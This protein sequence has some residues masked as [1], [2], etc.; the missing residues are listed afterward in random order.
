M[1]ILLPGVGLDPAL[2][3]HF[4]SS[5][6]IANPKPA[7]DGF[8]KLVELSKLPPEDILF[9]GDGVAKEMSP[10]KEVVLTTCLMWDASEHADYSFNKFADLLTVLG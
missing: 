7:L 8:Q 2:F 6:D 10:A 3:T 1:D 5:E 9:V 4:I